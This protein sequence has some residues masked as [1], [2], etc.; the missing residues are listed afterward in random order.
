MEYSVSVALPFADEF[1]EPVDGAKAESSGSSV[2]SWEGGGEGGSTVTLVTASG[3]LG[4]WTA[5]DDSRR[6]GVK[7]IACNGMYSYSRW[8]KEFTNWRR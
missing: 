1:E 6:R 3:R 8:P 2:A 4:M 7:S 5:C